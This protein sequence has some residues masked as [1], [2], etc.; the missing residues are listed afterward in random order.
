[1]KMETNM[2]GNEPKR[3]GTY[4]NRRLLQRERWVQKSPDGNLVLAFAVTKN[5]IDQ[6]TDFSIS[7][8]GMQEFYGVR[9][10]HFPDYQ[11]SKNTQ[12]T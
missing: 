7:E 9:W 8:S 1:M 6:G 12:K 10:G 4:D 2:Q 3:P 5:T 11:D